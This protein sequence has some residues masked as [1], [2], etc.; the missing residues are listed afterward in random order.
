MCEIIATATAP[1][2]KEELENSVNKFYAAEIK[3]LRSFIG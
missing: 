1:Y 2:L 3:S